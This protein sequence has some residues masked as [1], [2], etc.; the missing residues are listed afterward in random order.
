[1]RE[2]IKHLNELK[3]VFE[4]NPF[5]RK[6][7]VN[8]LKDYQF[9]S[10]RYLFDELVHHQFIVKTEE[11]FVFQHKGPIYKEALETMC[12]NVRKRNADYLKKYLSNKKKKN[13]KKS[14]IVSS[15]NLIEN[16][17]KLLKDNG[18]KILKPITNFEEI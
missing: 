11:G 5:T 6:S 16:A 9:P 15:E 8:A 12:K 3:K 4:L 2:K 13:T 17:I 10:A 18:Y 1:M 7:F 14:F